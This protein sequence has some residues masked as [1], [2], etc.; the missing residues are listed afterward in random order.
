MNI[1]VLGSGLAGLAVS[2]GLI[3]KN[4]QIC[5]DIV[6]KQHTFERRG[7]TFGLAPN[8]QIALQEL[9]PQALQHLQTVG[10]SMENTDGYMLPWWEVRDSLLEEARKHSD[11]ISIHMGMDVQDV[12]ECEDHV[13]VHFK[14]LDLVLE[15]S[16]LIG[17]DGV[18]SQIRTQVLGLP[19]AVPTGTYTWRGRINVNEVPSLRHLTNIDV[20]KSDTFGSKLLM[21]YFNFDE[22]LPGTIAWTARTQVPAIVRGVTTPL[23]LLEQHLQEECNQ[24]DDTEMRKIETAKEVFKHSL[25][26][27][28][29]YSSELCVIDLNAGWGGR[30]RITLIGDAAHAVRP[31]SGLGG[32]V[33]FE[34]AVILSRML[35]SMT[36]S[37]CSNICVVDA[38]RKFEAK[39]LPRVKNISDDQTRR[40]ESF[41][42]RSA[43]IPPWSDKY[44]EWVFAGPDAPSEPPQETSI[45]CV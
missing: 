10:I 9:C 11:R 43:S 24:Q 25:P 21:F 33:A 26:Q 15:G 38:L 14:G 35:T 28:L 41:Y 5:V 17:A 16:V 27:D 18:R 37:T 2:L 39:R 6:E 20:G 12:T 8:G 13:E 45:S 3:S 42:K 23:D 40:A 31:Y 44:R 30:G 19:P 1:I 29:T 7:A 4:D 36:P 34:D 32:S 22:T